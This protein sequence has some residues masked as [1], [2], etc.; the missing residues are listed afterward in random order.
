[1][2]KT[3]FFSF[4]SSLVIL[5]SGCNVNSTPE[6]EYLYMN[7]TFTVSNDYVSKIDNRHLDRVKEFNGLLDKNKEVNESILTLDDYYLNS[8]SKQSKIPTIK[9]RKPRLREYM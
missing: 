5:I 4:I 8:V 9:V 2:K 3:K 1:M 6:K 7:K